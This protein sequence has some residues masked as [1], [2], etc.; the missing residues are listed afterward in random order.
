MAGSV[1]LPLI[2]LQTLSA[3]TNIGF[4][5]PLRATTAAGAEDT[6]DYEPMVTVSA[7]SSTHGQCQ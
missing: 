1:A 7:D 2:E 4:V 6:W 5:I 3:T